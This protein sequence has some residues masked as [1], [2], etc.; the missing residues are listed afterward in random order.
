MLDAV[1]NDDEL[2]RIEE[3]LSVAKAHAQLPT[4]HK[5]KLVLAL[6]VV[7]DKFAPELDHLDLH[8]VDVSSY[9]GAP[10]FVESSEQ[11]RDVHL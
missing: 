1:G 7:P 4:D 5:E 11:L 3:D 6:M 9:L 2:A 10:R 8:V